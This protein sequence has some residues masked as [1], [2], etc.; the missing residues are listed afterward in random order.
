LIIAQ[1]V[2]V[3]R[4]LVEL[5]HLVG[6]VLLHHAAPDSVPPGVTGTET[7]VMLIVLG[8]IDVVMPQP[9][10]LNAIRLRANSFLAALGAIDDT[11]GTS[12]ATDLLDESRSHSICA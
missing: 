3:Y 6:F 5:W 8:L 12:K 4:F 7:I 10:R 9:R 11:P 2:Y 1:T